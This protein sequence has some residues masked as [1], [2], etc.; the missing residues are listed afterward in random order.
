MKLQNSAALPKRD[1][2]I[3]LGAF[4]CVVLDSDQNNFV[5]HALVDVTDGAQSEIYMFRIARNA[6]PFRACVDIYLFPFG[7]R[8]YEKGRFFN[9]TVAT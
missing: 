5:P 3:L 9:F 7:A 4:A 8:E 1:P 2:N 6:D